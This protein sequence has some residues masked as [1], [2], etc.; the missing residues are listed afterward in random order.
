MGFKRVRR[1]LREDNLLCI[2]LDR[3]GRHQSPSL[4]HQHLQNNALAIRHARDYHR[5]ASSVLTVSVIRGNKRRTLFYK[6]S[7]S[8]CDM[9]HLGARW[10]GGIW[11]IAD[12]RLRLRQRVEARRFVGQNGMFVGMDGSI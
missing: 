8:A 9:S 11:L 4:F 2:F 7:A 6:L 10:M 3:V 5:T 12:A 1:L